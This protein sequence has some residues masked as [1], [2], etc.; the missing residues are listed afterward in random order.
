MCVALA[1]CLSGIDSHLLHVLP[2]NVGINEGVCSA[3]P[4]C[5]EI[6]YIIV[7]THL[8]C[9]CQD[10]L[11]SLPFAGCPLQ[12]ALCRLP[13]AGCPLQAALCRLPSAGCPLQQITSMCDQYICARL[14][15]RL[16]SSISNC[17]AF[18]HAY[19]GSWHFA[20]VCWLSSAL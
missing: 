13:F 12:A 6:M 11:G 10:G 18:L 4:Q 3:H 20:F 2:V 14:L 8:A 16:C 9:I 15:S 19:P 17:L 5:Q 1:P 7:W